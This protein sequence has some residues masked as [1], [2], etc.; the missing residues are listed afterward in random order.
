MYSTG[1]SISIYNNFV[2]SVI[3][4]NTKLQ[5]CIPETNITLYSQLCSNNEKK[6]KALCNEKDNS[7]GVRVT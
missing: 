1:N 7:F 5:C 4:K 6:K 3:Y 2:W